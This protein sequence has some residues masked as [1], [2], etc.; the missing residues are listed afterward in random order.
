MY[1]DGLVEQRGEH[2]RE[3]IARLTAAVGEAASESGGVRSRA[4]LERL[5][6]T[7]LARLTSE[8]PDDDVA[9]LAVRLAD[10]PGA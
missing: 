1:T 9:V 3:G 4:H 5:V 8:E 10:H 6:D 2:L 7:V